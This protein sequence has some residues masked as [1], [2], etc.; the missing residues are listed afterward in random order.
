MR[1]RPEIQAVGSALGELLIYPL[2]TAHGGGLASHQDFT[3]G[4]GCGIFSL[5][6][7]PSISHVES[8]KC[9]TE[10]TVLAVILKNSSLITLIKHKVTVGVFYIFQS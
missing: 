10:S 1:W 6:G 7:L 2:P 3:L 5:L 8:F 9:S 4:N